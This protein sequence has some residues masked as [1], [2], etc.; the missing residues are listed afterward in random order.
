MQTTQAPLVEKT[1]NN[2]TTYWCPDC[3]K[4]AYEGK[5][6]VHSKRCDHN[7]QPASIVEKSARESETNRLYVFSR[8][9]KSTGFCGGHHDDVAA[10]VARGY[11]TQS[12]AMNLDD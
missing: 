7:G 9:V 4:W 3:N 10:C 8:Q 5:R 2:V 11:L 6:I 12:D 1:L